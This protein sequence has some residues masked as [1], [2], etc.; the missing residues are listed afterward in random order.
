MVTNVYNSAGFA[1]L[2]YAKSDKGKPNLLSDLTAGATDGTGLNRLYAA[3]TADLSL[4]DDER[5]NIEGDD[6]VDAQFSFEATELLSF[7]MSLGR[8]DFSFLNVTQGTSSIDLQSESNMVLLQPQDRSF[9]DMFFMLSRRSLDSDG[10][11]KYAN[12]IVPQATGT[13]LGSAFGTRAAG[14]FNYSITANRTVN[15]FYGADLS[16]SL[17]GKTKSVAFEF[18]TDKP[19]MIDV[20]KQDAA[21]T[22]FTPSQPIDPNGI[23]IGWQ[24]NESTGTVGTVSL[25]ESSGDITFT[26][27][28]EDDYIYALYEIL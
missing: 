17:G 21:S 1:R 8:Q 19:A 12:V 11:S 26:A 22:A 16:A 18:I 9:T 3:Q 23:L 25:T 4:A 7:N 24:Y 27:V 20:W 28:D 6:G 10:V 14:A 2:W 5:V 15:T 13:Y